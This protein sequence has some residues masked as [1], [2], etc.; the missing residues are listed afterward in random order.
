VTAV[1]VTVM[2][3]DDCESDFSGHCYSFT[4]SA[5]SYTA[6]A[7]AARGPATEDAAGDGIIIARATAI[8]FCFRR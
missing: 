7:I 3:N 8:S 6:R 2:S 4:N 5:Q 1:T